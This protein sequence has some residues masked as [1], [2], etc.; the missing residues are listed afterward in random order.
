MSKALAYF[1][2][3]NGMKLFFPTLFFF[4][5]KKLHIQYNQH[6]CIYIHV[7]FLIL[8]ISLSPF[9]IFLVFLSVWSSSL[10]RALQISKSK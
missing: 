2:I 7:S 5:S 4:T 10:I 9:Y 8:S 1:G 3:S 6:I